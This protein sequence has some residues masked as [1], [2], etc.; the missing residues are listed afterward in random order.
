MILFIVAV[1]WGHGEIEPQCR[2]REHHDESMKYWCTS[3]D[4]FVLRKGSSWEFQLSR[5]VIQMRGGYARTDESNLPRPHSFAVWFVGLFMPSPAQATHNAYDSR[6]EHC[7]IR[8][9]RGSIISCP[10]V[11]K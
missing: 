8:G 3:R 6:R 2:Q 5:D 11:G 9:K 4:L 1:R 7:N 10:V